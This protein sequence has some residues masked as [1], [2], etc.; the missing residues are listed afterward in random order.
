MD[1]FAQWFWLM[2]WWFLFFA[3]L[4]ILFQ[5]IGDLFRDKE[6]SGWLKAVWM[7][8]L[9]FLPFLTAFIYVVSRGRSM[10]ERQTAAMVQAKEDTDTYIRGVAGKSPASQISDAKALLDQGAI[11][12]QEFATLKA[13]ALA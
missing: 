7:I 5:I 9:V 3:Y 10:A 4:V 11:N 1:T 13:R 8:A 2:V 6:L 12:E